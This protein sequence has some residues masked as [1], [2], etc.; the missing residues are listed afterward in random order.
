MSPIPLTNGNSFKR[1]CEGLQ[2]VKNKKFTQI[3][4]KVLGSEKLKDTK[5]GKCFNLNS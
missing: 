1:I 4:A 2:R 5:D 3:L